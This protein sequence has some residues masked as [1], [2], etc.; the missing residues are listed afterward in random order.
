[1]HGDPKRRRR[2]TDPPLSRGGV[3]EGKR[4]PKFT[5]GASWWGGFMPPAGGGKGKPVSLRAPV[6]KIGESGL[7]RG[8]RKIFGRIVA[9]GPHYQADTPFQ[10]TWTT[11]AKKVC[12]GRLTKMLVGRRIEPL[13]C[14]GIAPRKKISLIKGGSKH[15][16]KK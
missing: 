7:I 2:P 5:T 3:L 16:E 13:R 15:L 9:E 1:M 10:Q 4:P 12:W 11:Y 6:P 14:G 8:H